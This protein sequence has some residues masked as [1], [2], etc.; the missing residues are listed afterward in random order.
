MEQTAVARA[1][2]A[3]LD[4]QDYERLATLLAPEFV[5]ERPDLTLEGRERFVQ[6][7][8]EERPQQDT[9]H[10]ITAVYRRDDESASEVSV[11]GRLLS[12][13][14]EC[15]VRFVDVFQFSQRC[16]RRIETYTR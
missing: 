5:Q 8:R 13:D 12:A 14:G 1:Y 9:T 7:M 10:R 16:I 15:I 2:Y 3:A 4:E 6:F 11:R